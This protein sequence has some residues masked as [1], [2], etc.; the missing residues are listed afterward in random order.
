MK[1]FPEPN[2]NDASQLPADG[3]LLA[4]RNQIKSL[5]LDLQERDKKIELLNQELERL[6]LNQKDLLKETS[7]AA[8]E[9]LFSSL[10]PAVA[11]LVTQAYLANQQ[12]KLIQSK[13]IL[14]VAQR[15]ISILEQSGLQ[16]LGQPGQQVQ[17]DPRLHTPLSASNSFTTGQAVVVR[18]V[19]LSYRG[20]IIRKAGVELLEGL[21]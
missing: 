15:L 8:L 14:L 4:L 7:T 6:R 11:Q 12:N 19:G 9:E 17:F 10:S 21:S 5:Q 18:F 13:D 1:L 16:L 3:D 20:K 2:Q